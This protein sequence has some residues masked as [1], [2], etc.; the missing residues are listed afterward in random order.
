[1]D[2]RKAIRVAEGKRELLPQS[3]LLDPSIDRA[4]QYYN[5][6]MDTPGDDVWMAW[7]YETLYKLK[8]KNEQKLKLEDKQTITRISYSFRPGYAMT[9]PYVE[10][11]I[12]RII[13]P[14]FR[15]RRAKVGWNS[16]GFDEP[17]AIF[18]EGMELNGDL[19]DGMDMFHTFQP[20]VERN[21]EFATSI[22]SEHLKP[23]KHLSQSEPE[24]YSAQ[25]SDATI[26]DAY[27]LRDIMRSREIPEYADIPFAQPTLEEELRG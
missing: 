1:M 15:A 21:L 23:W 8:N 25:D 17:I 9:V 6:Y 3:Y 14:I 16:R 20:N 22:L 18:Q 27:R 13:V 7:D 12:S 2:V 4:V 26:T 24:W 19:H 11:F 10:P 5:E